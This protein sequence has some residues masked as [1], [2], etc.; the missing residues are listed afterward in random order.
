[1]Q[2]CSLYLRIGASNSLKTRAECFSWRDDFGSRGRVPDEFFESEQGA[3]HICVERQARENIHDIEHCWPG[4]ERASWMESGQRHFHGHR[5]TYFE[6]RLRRKRK[7]DES[8]NHGLVRRVDPPTRDLS[9]ACPPPRSRRSNLTHIRRTS[10]HSSCPAHCP[11]TLPLQTPF[12]EFL[13]SNIAP[14]T[15]AQSAI[16]YEAIQT[17]RMDASRVETALLQLSARRSELND[18]IRKNSSILSILSQIF[19]RCVHPKDTFNPRRHAAW[20]VARVCRRW[21]A[22]AIDT[23]ELWRHFVLQDSQFPQTYLRNSV[24]MQLQRGR[25]A[26][27]SIQ[28]AAGPTMLDV[29]DVLFAAAA[30]WEAV[31]FST[32]RQLAFFVKYR[33]PYPLLRKLCFREPK[34]TM[35]FGAPSQ[36]LDA[37]MVNSLPGLTDLVWDAPRFPN[38][39]PLPWAQLSLCELRRVRIADVQWILSFLPPTTHVTAIDI[40]AGNRPSLIAKESQIQSLRLEHSSIV[41]VALT[42]PMLK[43]LDMDARTNHIRKNC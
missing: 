34:L 1:M 25:H 3:G 33:S 16:I 39:L 19:D 6:Q 29:M 15:D 32:E 14:S 18:F 22:I 27:L 23:P 28:L 36:P 41:L 4:G 11:A 40:G 12:P 35:R 17:A 10:C 43:K 30:Q 31:T 38:Q 9:S 24:K 13:S 5:W 2:A 21:R 7:R 8:I 42:A 20:V 37:D 26:P